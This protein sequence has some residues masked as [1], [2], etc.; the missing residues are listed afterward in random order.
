MGDMSLPNNLSGLNS[1][2][3]QLREK[4]LAWID[5]HKDLRDH[6]SIAE[7][8]MDLIHYAV[9]HGPNS[10]DDQRALLGLGIRVFNDLAAAWKLVAGGYFQIGAAVQRDVIET[11][12]LVNYLRLKPDLIVVWRT[13]DKR[14]KDRELK[15]FVVRKALDDAMG[16]GPSKRG[17]IYAKFSTLATHPTIEGFPLLCPNGTDAAVGPFMELRLLRALLEEHAKVALQA[18]MCF[19]SLLPVDTLEARVLAHR[20]LT[21]MMDWMERYHGSTYSDEERARTDQ[22]LR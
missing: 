19:N 15:P 16:Q 22:L 11:V 12:N 13:G 7:T 18:G 10:T 17:A 6:L 4:A 3:E 1:Q 20:M 2:E 21:G 8:A 9:H 14:T 5:K